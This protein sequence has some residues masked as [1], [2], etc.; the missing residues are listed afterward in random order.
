MKSATFAALGLVVLAF[1]AGSTAHAHGRSH[2]HVGVYLGG[3]VIMPGPYYYPYP[4]L[5]YPGWPYYGYPPPVV[6]VPIPSAPP[7]YVERGPDPAAP[8]QPAAA[9]WYWCQQPQGYYPNVT[10]CPG[11]WISVPAR[12]PAQAPARP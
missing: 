3:P 12:P 6:T 4:R 10:E 1:A 2:G 8:A 5:A 9:S 7:V 11:G